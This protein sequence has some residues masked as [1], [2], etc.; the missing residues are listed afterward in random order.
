M[1]WERLF[2]QIVA[3]MADETER[4]GRPMYTKLTELPVTGIVYFTATI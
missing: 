2:I 3:K 4:I 1:D